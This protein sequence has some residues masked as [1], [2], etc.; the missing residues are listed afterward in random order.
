MDWEGIPSQLN[1]YIPD[2]SLVACDG[3]G[4]GID[5]AVKYVSS[6]NP[7]PNLNSGAQV[8]YDTLSNFALSLDPANGCRNTSSLL[9]DDEGFAEYEE[10]REVAIAQLDLAFD[11]LRMM[12]MRGLTTDPDVFKSLMEACGRCGDTKRA[13][14]LI[15]VMKR[16]GLVANNDVLVYFMLSFAQYDEQFSSRGGL[17]SEDGDSD[18]YS[19]F[20]KKKLINMDGF[21]GN[22][23]DLAF[24]TDEEM[25]DYL[26]DSGSELSGESGSSPAFLRYFAPNMTQTKVK[27]RKKRRKKKSSSKKQTDNLSDRIKKQLVL[28]ESLLDFLYP[29]ICI[30]TFGDACPMCSNVMKEEDIVNGWKQCDFEDFTTA[31]PL[32][33]HRFVPR[34]KVSCD[35]STF[36]G[37]Q[38]PGTPLYCEFLSPW[39][40]RKELGYIIGNSKSLHQ[41]LD[42]SWRSG[43]DVRATIWW[44]LIAM[45]KRHQLPFSFLLQGSFRNRLIHPVPQDQ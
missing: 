14:E 17:K 8:A 7:C 12:E 2:C 22:I 43:N 45:F 34:F 44:N 20:L 36:E 13:I 31:C 9:D 23:Y 25:S 39:A 26:S 10:A 15:E 33:S 32:C 18:A 38:G 24:P 37:S 6:N 27:K 16:E 42:P 41:I 4:K 5:D 40:L 1:S 28:G 3:F 29:N 30:D 35:S 19:L 11:A 21:E